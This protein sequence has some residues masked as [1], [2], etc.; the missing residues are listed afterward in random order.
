MHATHAA[1]AC[2]LRT[3]TAWSSACLLSHGI[4]MA[5]DRPSHELGAFLLTFADQMR[6]AACRQCML[7]HVGNHIGDSGG[8]RIAE[9]IKVNKTIVHLDLQGSS[10]DRKCPGRGHIWVCRDTRYS[11]G[12][13]DA[14]DAQD[15]HIA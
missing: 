13:C 8:T 3:H 11:C 15:K 10:F 6:A 14:L 12:A 1:H 4:S 9:A 2:S 7:L 5:T